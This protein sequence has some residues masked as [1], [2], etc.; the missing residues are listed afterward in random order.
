M[1]VR[2]WRVWGMSAVLAGGLVALG[3]PPRSEIGGRAT[4]TIT[5]DYF[6]PEPASVKVLPRQ[7]RESE[8]SKTTPPTASDLIFNAVTASKPIGGPA[9]KAR[10][11]LDIADMH[12]D[13][14]ELDDARDWYLEVLH[15]A[16]GSIHAAMAAERL[17]QIKAPPPP[18][19]SSEPPLAGPPSLQV[20]IR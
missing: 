20:R 5:Q 14:C 13:A 10:C 11:A 1:A 12:F 4:P 16:P 17:D 3:Q 15:L 9:W 18:V 7:V 2:A 19:Q 6:Q 8:L